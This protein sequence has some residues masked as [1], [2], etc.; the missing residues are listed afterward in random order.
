MMMTFQSYLCFY[1]EHIIHTVHKLVL[2]IIKPL[3]KKQKVDR[4]TMTTKKT[5]KSQLRIKML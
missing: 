3:E 1:Y 5:L 4:Q 2:E